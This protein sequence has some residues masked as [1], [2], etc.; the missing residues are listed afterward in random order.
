LNGEKKPFPVVQTNFEERDGQFSPDGKW[1]AYQSNESGRFEIYI[2]PFPGPGGQYQITT[3]GGVQVRWAPNG[4][5][6]FYI[7]LDGRLMSVPIQFASNGQ[8]VEAGAPLPLF[9]TRVARGVQGDF[10]QQY[11]VSPDGR[12]FL[13]NT[14]LEEATS[15]IT[16]ILNWKG[17]P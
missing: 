8:A 1:I 5:E 13:I 4:K 17:K 15:P 14:V 12:R 16:V 9:A 7:A 10:S 3:D 11:V 6:L 2:Q